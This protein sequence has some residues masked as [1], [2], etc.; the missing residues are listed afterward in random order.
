MSE[1]IKK[2]E[3]ILYIALPILILVACYGEFIL[4]F[5]RGY[6]ELWYTILVPSIVCTILTI[7]GYKTHLKWLYFI[8]TVIIIAGTVLLI[9]FPSYIM[10]VALICGGISLIVEIVLLVFHFLKKRQPVTE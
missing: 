10:F 2:I 1:R 7:F 5:I 8:A 3:H 9:G 6:E 4:C